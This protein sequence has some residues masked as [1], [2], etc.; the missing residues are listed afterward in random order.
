MNSGDSDENYRRQQKNDS[1]IV[2]AWMLEDV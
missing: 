2:N 1:T